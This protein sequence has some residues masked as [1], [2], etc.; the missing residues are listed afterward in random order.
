MIH[1]GIV[2]GL[3]FVNHAPSEGG[4]QCWW[5]VV[6]HDGGKDSQTAGAQGD[7]STASSSSR[8]S[9]SAGTGPHNSMLSNAEVRLQL[10][11]G[12]RVRAREE[13]LMR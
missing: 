10:Y 7:S 6:M 9:A 3:D 11:R 12:A 1:E 2:P 8:G 5:E 13:V 4:A